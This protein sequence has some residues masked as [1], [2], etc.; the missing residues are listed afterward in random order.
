MSIKYLSKGTRVFQ[1][2]TFGIRPEGHCIVRN[3]V[4]GNT[5]DSLSCS[6]VTNLIFSLTKKFENRA[7]RKQW[8]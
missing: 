2:T 8:K 1:M 4:N 6:A 7:D 5:T 3:A